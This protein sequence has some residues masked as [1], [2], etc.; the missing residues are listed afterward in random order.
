MFTVY[1]WNSY[2]LTVW[3]CYKQ[4]KY[5]LAQMSKTRNGLSLSPVVLVDVSFTVLPFQYLPTSEF[6]IVTLKKTPKVRLTLYDSVLI[7]RG[8]FDVS[9]PT[10]RS[11]LSNP[12]IFRV[13]KKML[14]VTCHANKPDVV[15]VHQGSF[16]IA[17]SCTCFQPTTRNVSFWSI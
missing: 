2:E 3:Y 9:S 12:K 6:L 7:K 13:S 15:Y 4:N 1:T 11:I 14:P 10:F 16:I 17:D 8:T 5:L